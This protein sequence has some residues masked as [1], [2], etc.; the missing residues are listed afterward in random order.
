MS[1]KSTVNCCFKHKKPLLKTNGRNWQEKWPITKELRS[2]KLG[3][4][5]IKH[6]C[7]EK[8]SWRRLSPN[9]R[10][11]GWFSIK[12]VEA[13]WEFG[14]TYNQMRSTTRINLLAMNLTKQRGRENKLKLKGR[15]CLIKAIDKLNQVLLSCKKTEQKYYPMNRKY[16]IL[17]LLNQLKRRN[18]FKCH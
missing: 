10:P 2:L 1:Q 8:T 12:T 6:I 16:L 5:R 7:W 11:K 13:I 9:N 17:S 3:T 4:L 15:T 18:E 14:M